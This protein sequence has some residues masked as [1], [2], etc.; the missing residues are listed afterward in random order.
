MKMRNRTGARNDP[1]GTPDST[2]TGFEAKLS[3]TTY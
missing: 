1:L 2:G 3:K